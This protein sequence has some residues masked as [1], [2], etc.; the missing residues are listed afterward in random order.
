MKAFAPLCAGVFF[1]A[2]N[3]YSGSVIR[4]DFVGGGPNGAPPALAPADIAGAVPASN[5]NDVAQDVASGLAGSLMDNSGAQTSAAIVWSS[6]NTWSTVIPDINADYE[7]MKGYL[8]NP[9][10]DIYVSFSGVPYPKFDVYV[11][12]N[13]DNTSGGTVGSYSIGGSKIFG[14]D[15]G[16]LF[17]GTFTRAYGTNASDTNAL[18]N[19][20]VF[21]GLSGEG[22]KLIGRPEDSVH[23]SPVN[24]LQIVEAHLR[25]SSRMK[26]LFARAS[27]KLNERVF[28]PG[29]PDDPVMELG[30]ETLL[31][32][33]T[34]LLVHRDRPLEM[35]KAS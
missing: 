7:M 3:G 34:W 30:Q 15:P 27:A 35:P 32:N 9:T 8:D 29:E 17:N 5:W 24:G 33:A 6:D 25:E 1:L 20:V 12:F 23:R 14:K 28:Q 18:G 31:E 13:D 10:N 21:Q 22:F 4:V 26:D 11:Y 16:A 2:T 19:Y